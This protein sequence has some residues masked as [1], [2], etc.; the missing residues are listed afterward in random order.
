MEYDDAIKWLYALKIYGMSLGLER[1]EHLLSL[2]GSP[3]KQLKAIHIAGTNGKGSVAAMLS[4][5]LQAA[6]YKAALFTSPHLISFE[7][8]IMIN[9]KKIPKE[10]LCYWVERIRPLAEDMAASGEFEHPT[11]FEIAS[12]IAFSHFAKERVD[13]AI[14]EVGLGGRLDATNVV[15]PE[16]SVITTIALDHTHVLG[17]TLSEV[18]MEK[19]GIIK[20]GAPVVTGIEDEDIL[21]MIEEVCQSK[22]SPLFPTRDRVSAVLKASDLYG[23]TFDISGLG[24]GYEDLTLHLLGEHQIK[25]AS[26]AALVID[27]MK[28]KGVAIPDRAIREGFKN[29]K[30]PARFEIVQEKPII[31]LDC[32]HNPAGM[33]ALKRA[34]TN[35]LSGRRLTLVLG[36]MRDKDIAGI[37]REIAPKAASIIITKPKFERA[38]EPSVIEEEARKYGDSVVVIN[39]VSEA[40]NHAKRNTTKFDVICVTGSIFNV[41]EAMEALGKIQ[42]V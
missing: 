1:I 28:N 18:T 32:A 24:T 23:Q 3:H 41:G 35:T 22:K 15:T 9:G 13:Y 4:S 8:R 37:V 21:G 25:N 30:W 12:A 5:I 6:G 7:E 38:A 11:F 19:A 16:V 39:S 36:I 2:L 17:T 26:V 27:V 14:L 42:K 31:L 20:P 29:A 40:I 10:R 34:L 33:R